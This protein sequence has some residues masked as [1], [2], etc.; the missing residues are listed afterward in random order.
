MTN[1]VVR[2][3]FLA[4]PFRLVD[5]LRRTG[6]NGKRVTGFTP[7]LD[8]RE[9]EEEYWLLFDLPGVKPE[10]VSIEVRDQTLTVSG[11]RVPATEPGRPQQLERP[12]GSFVRSLTIPKGVERDLITAEYAHGVLTMKVPKAAAAK[13]KKISISTSAKSIGT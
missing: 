5:E 2:D 13:P 1:L 3:P 12:F 6:G 8:I 10:D 4:T 7:A 11:T 9:T